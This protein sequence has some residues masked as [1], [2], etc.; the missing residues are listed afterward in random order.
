M[1]AIQTGSPIS[2]SILTCPPDFGLMHSQQNVKGVAPVDLADALLSLD[3]YVRI[4]FLLPLLRSNSI[5]ELD[6]NV[7]ATYPV[8][9]RL[10]QIRGELLQAIFLNKP[11]LAPAFIR[12]SLVDLQTL[13][14]TRGPEE[15][16]EIASMNCSALVKTTSLIL[17][18]LCLKSQTQQLAEPVAGTQ[19]IGDFKEVSTQMSFY[20]SAISHLLCDRI[21]DV[22][23][24]VVDELAYR[25]RS[26]AQ[27]LYVI[28]SQNGWIGRASGDF[29][30]EIRADEEDIL[31]AKAGVESYFKGLP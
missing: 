1:T 22:D 14:D 20:L 15:L 4:N 28:T 26:S 19:P 25:A 24:S 21:Q 10:H 16:S 23:R 8:Y 30:H 6:S 31:L 7:H 18:E 2:P 13:I 11:H 3:H 17:E 9:E 5:E 27:Q 29:P 12:D